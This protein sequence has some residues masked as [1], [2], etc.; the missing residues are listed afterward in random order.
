MHATEEERWF[1]GHSGSLTGLTGLTGLALWPARPSLVSVVSIERVSLRRRMALRLRLASGMEQVSGSVYLRTRSDKQESSLAHFVS[2]Q[3]Q[4][5]NSLNCDNCHLQAAI[6]L[7]LP[8][9]RRRSPDCRLWRHH[10]RLP[11][12]VLFSFF[13]QLHGLH[14]LHGGHGLQS[15]TQSMHREKERTDN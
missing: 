10:L 11:L 7:R 6:L 5:S 1:V 14:S 8:P 4:S 12:P 9:C 3:S 15:C 2:T 13:R